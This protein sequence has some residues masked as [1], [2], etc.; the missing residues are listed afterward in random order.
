MAQDRAQAAREREALLLVHRDL[1]HAG[2]LV[3]DRVLDGDDLVQPLVDLGNRGVQRS[4]LAAAG[5][6]GD[7][8]HAVRLGRELAHA[9]DDVFVEAQAV[10]REAAQLIAERAAIQY[11]QHRVLAEHARHHRDAEVDLAACLSAMLVACLE[12]AVLRH[13]TLGDVQL[14]QH[15][16]AREHV[17]RG[18]QALD[19]LDH[20]QH[21]VDPVL[22]RQAAAVRF[23]MDVAGQGL[24]RIV[25][26]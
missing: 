5:G 17:V 25:N 4:G 10:E 13:A 18:L 8:Q 11:P 9:L 23:E 1:Q 2:Q 22:D 19:P 12:A 6:A 21:A 3:L 26:G 14:G 24:E 15:F 7:E 16:D 20:L